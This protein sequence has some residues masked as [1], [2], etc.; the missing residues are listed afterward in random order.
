MTREE[1][2]EVYNGLINTKIKEAFEFFAPELKEGEDER[3]R[4]GLIEAL[5]VSKT[6]GELKFVLPE[7]TRE[8][9]LAYLEKQKIN[10]DGDFARGYDC[11]FAVCLNS[12]GAEWFEKQKV[13]KPNYCH[14]E[15]DETGWTEEYRKAYY[16]GWNNCNMQH[17]QLKAGQKSMDWSEGDKK[18]LDDAYCWLCEYAG[19][20]IQKN[21]EKSSMLYEIA[22]KL[23]SIYSQPK[24]EWS[25]EDSDNLERIDNY[26]WMLDD[27]VGDDCTIP[28]GKTDKIRGNIQEV[29]SPWLKSLPERFNLQPKQEWSGEDKKLIDDVMNSLCCYQNTLSHY[30]KEIV[31]EEIRKLKSLKPQPKHEWSEE[32]EKMRDR[33][34]DRLQ[35][36]TLSTRTD[37][38]SPNITFFDEID[39]LKSIHPSW[40]PSEEQMEALAY[41]GKVLA[42]RATKAY[43]ELESLREQLKKLK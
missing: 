23:K 4:K 27:Y 37:T 3:I 29:L 19:S 21:H 24:R 28:Q 26:L 9:C 25:E 33:L 5:K 40:K 32:D 35:F 7:P 34:I 6:V 30:Q 11:G 38:T 12:H 13:Q 17:D 31:G 8:E 10:T 2:I 15:V 18:A 22:N 1:A 42:P 43:E 41:A 36:I 16:D 39:W 14:H 20:L